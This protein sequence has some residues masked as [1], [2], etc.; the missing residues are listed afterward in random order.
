VNPWSRGGKLIGELSGAVGGVVVDYQNFQSRILTED[1]RYDEGEVDSLIV[2]GDYDQKTFS[3]VVVDELGP[4][5][6]RL[7]PARCPRWLR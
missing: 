1:R 6:W 4:K 2:S 7:P 5:Q 3:H